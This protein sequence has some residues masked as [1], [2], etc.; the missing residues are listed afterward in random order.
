MS[1]ERLIEAE[2]RI[3]FADQTIKQLSDVVYDQQKQIDALSKAIDTL[4]RRL[5]DR[6]SEEQVVDTPP[7]H[8]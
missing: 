6:G 2:S 7:P 3:T 4:K 8:Y 5:D 1:E